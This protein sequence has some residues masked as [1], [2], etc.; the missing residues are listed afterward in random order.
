M[1][2][3]IRLPIASNAETCG[4]CVACDEFV[5]GWWWCRA[6]DQQLMRPSDDATPSRAQECLDAE[7]TEEADRE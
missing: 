1:R 2:R 6:F 3:I 7:V 4:S 5:P